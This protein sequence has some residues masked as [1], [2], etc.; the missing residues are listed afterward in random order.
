MILFWGTTGVALVLR[1]IQVLLMSDASVNPHWLRPVMDA[2]VYDEMARGLASGDWPTSLPFFAAPLY[3]LVL[4]ALYAVLGAAHP[5]PVLLVHALVSALGAGF[6]AL[7]AACVWDRRAGWLAGLIYATLWISIFFAAELLAVSFTAP[8][9]LLVLWLVL[10]E[11]QREGGPTPRGLLL[12]GLALGAAVI[13]RP[14]LLVLAPVI[15]WYLHRH[16]KLVRG[17]RGWLALAVGL[18]LPILPITAHNLIRAGSPVLISNSGG[19]NFYIGNNAQADGSSVVIPEI[20]PTRSDMFENLRRAAERETGRSLSPVAVDRHYLGKGLAFWTRHPGQALGLQFTKL[21]LL[22]AAHERSNTKNLYF[23]RDRSALLRWPIWL[24]WT[25]VLLLAVVGFWRRDLAPGPRFLL[26]AAAAAFAVTLL[27]FFVNGRFRLPL[28]AML[29]V[30]AGGGLD[31]AWRSLRQRRW[32]G[33]RAALI[34]AAVVV[35]VSWLPDLATYNPRDSFGDPYV[36]YSLGNSYQAKGDKRRAVESFERA[37]AQQRAYPQPTFAL[38]E[39]PLYTALGQLYLERRQG[40]KA[41]QLYEAWVRENPGS[42]EARVRL[43]EM[44]L[45]AGQLEE[46]QVQFDAILAQDPENRAASI[47]KGWVLYYTGHFAEAYEVL[48]AAHRREPH[49]HAL[50][51]AGLA[52]IEL[53]RLDEAERTFREV[54]AIEPRYWQAWGNLAGIYEQQGDLV[55]A[56]RAYRKVLEANPRDGAARQWLRE[57]P[58]L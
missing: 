37:L 31:L 57:H 4:G 3:P 23:W 15:A 25:P 11:G 44:L 22:L 32:D 28:L 53:G 10:R 30:P 18:I 17:Q 36:W 51:G 56:A 13:A 48:E 24:G 42:I 58:D 5:L 19:V 50:F 35:A 16:V 26:P 27:L 41:M 12:A 33:P 8:L 43:G 9:V 52:L 38:I 54:L 20:P 21:R 29:C 14:N 34:A 49:P 6:A 2:A 1:V 47:G 55:E 7:A 45:Q 40:P 46:A 39:E